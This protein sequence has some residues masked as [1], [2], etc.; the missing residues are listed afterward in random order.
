VAPILEQL[1][2]RVRDSAV[3]E[4][5]MRLRSGPWPTDPPSGPIV[6]APLARHFVVG[7]GHLQ[8]GDIEAAAGAFRTA[9]QVAPDFIPAMAY[10]GACYAA[11]GKDKEAASAWQ[12]ALLRDRASDWIHRLAIEAW[13][14]A[15]RPS[16]ALALIKQARQRFP[17]DDA[18]VRLQMRADLA[19]GR[20]RE[21]L[22]ALESLKEPDETSVLM[23]LAT[24]YAA[25]REGKPIWDPERDVAAMRRWREVYAVAGGGS[26]SI[27]DRWIAEVSSERSPGR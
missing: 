14:R 16:A 20:A 4:A 26:L 25:A 21:A 23:A 24:L 10:L 17:D 19:D 3:S 12:M 13:L 22:A 9:L 5:L 15:G 7:L 8:A 18:F 11:G 1:G 27:V 2:Q 6:S